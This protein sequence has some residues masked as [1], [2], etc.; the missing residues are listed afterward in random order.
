MSKIEAGKLP[1]NCGFIKTKWCN[2]QVWVTL[3]DRICSQDCKLQEVQKLL[4]ALASHIVQASSELTKQLASSIQ[5]QVDSFDIKVSFRLLKYALSLAVKLNQSINLLRR[6]FIKPSLPVQCASLADIA[7][8][9][10]EHIF[11]DSITD[12]LESLKK[13]NQIKALQGTRPDLLR[14]WKHS[15]SKQ[16]SN[17]KLSSKTLK[18]TQ[19]QG[20]YVR[21][22]K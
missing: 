18:R 8:D 6:L 9:S 21:R 1:A 20:H 19:H 10:P 13:E 16:S 5:P 15:F 4:T 2:T 3:V 11:G 7:D 17:F 12:S 22:S 14:K